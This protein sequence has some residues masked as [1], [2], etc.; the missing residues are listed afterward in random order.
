MTTVADSNFW[1]ADDKLPISQKSVSV[2]SANGLTYSGGQR[3]SIEVPPTI[4]YIQP[5]ECYLSFD[6]KIALPAAV[7][8]TALQLDSVLGGQSVIK[9]LRI[10]S[11][12]AG[13][14]LLEEFQDYNVLTNIKYTYS[15]ND[16]MRA[17]RALTEGATVWSSD[18]RGTCGTT[19]SHQ[20][21]T[22][23]N[24]WFRKNPAGFVDD[25]TDDNFQTVK[26]LLPINTGLFQNS[27]ILP[28]L[29]LDGLVL[30]IILEDAV[31]CV[32]QLDT[33]R[34]LT[35]QGLK[36]VFHSI[37]GVLGAA[38]KKVT[39]KTNFKTLYLAN[40]NNIFSVPNCPFVEGERV[41]FVELAT[42]TVTDT[43]AAPFVIDTITLF[44]AGGIT[45]LV[46]LTAVANCQSLTDV[47]PAGTYGVYSMSI[48][49][50]IAAG[51]YTPSYTVSNVE[52]I[53]QQLEMPDGYT[54]KMR[55]MMK[56]GGVMNYDYLSFTNYKYSQ[57]SSD[58]VTNMRL[59]LNQ[60]RCKAI[61]SVPTDSSIYNSAIA[62]SGGVN[63]AAAAGV[64]TY[65]Y[66]EAFPSSDG[67]WH[68]DTSGMTGITDS[69]NNY[70]YFYD[71]K[72]NPSRKVDCVKTSG[73]SISQQPLIELEKS[74]AQSDII[75]YSF[76][77]FKESFVLGRALSLHNGVYDARGRDFNIQLEYDAGQYKNKLWH[78]FVS[79][80]RR[81][82]FKGDGIRVLV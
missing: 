58:T 51:S 14:V 9:D 56:E 43:D 33:T 10:Y 21:A 22:S 82:E 78:N 79:H 53:L 49:E 5:R 29:M 48:A 75:P 70:Q 7:Q 72:L 64:K 63:A 15:T 68:S 50:Q 65:Q 73:V 47:D 77:M 38:A 2:P 67:S 46:L 13:K 4:E 66:A 41:N 45:D 60:S 31:R 81:I 36:P 69:L 19:Q 6:I 40:D 3:I 42:G 8:P 34:L 12:G 32:K 35:R 17:K 52:L 76:R 57:L 54:S 24:P 20:S 44:P 1:T 30:D 28:V 11:G 27:K 16:V 25:F 74:L 61:L 18:N 71:G 80:I 59:P 39:A 26:C 55:S 62:L 23:S 37:D